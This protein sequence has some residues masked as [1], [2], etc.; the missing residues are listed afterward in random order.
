MNE[1][2][3]RR[4]PRVQS[5]LK[6]EPE[7][8]TWAPGA[9]DFLILK[10]NQYLPARRRIQ[11]M[12]GL[13]DPHPYWTI[14]TDVEQHVVG[15]RMGMNRVEG[16]YVVMV[17]RVLDETGRLIGMGRKTEY[18]ENFPDYLEKAE[19]GAIARAL[20]V[21]GYGTESALDLD[22]GID[23]ERIADAPVPPKVTKSSGPAVA[24]GGKPLDPTEA[25]VREVA[26][27]MRKMDID[28]ET[29]LALANTVF[30]ESVSLPA[31]EE[32]IG[33]FLREYFSSKTPEK[34][35][36]LISTLKEVSGNG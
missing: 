18:S 7:P 11:W 19:T 36:Q 25:Q 33:P 5:E 9:G 32:E 23:K 34:L 17:A 30:D 13:P 24:R 22:E 28:P 3:T 26:Y 35:G 21:C 8:K 1:P 16:G 2:R 6:S 20:A 15:K 27:L 4:K 29:L 10:G 14:E 31:N 12:R